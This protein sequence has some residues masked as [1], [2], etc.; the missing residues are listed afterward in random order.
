MTCSHNVIRIAAWRLSLRICHTAESCQ[1]CWGLTYHG[2]QLRPGRQLG[3]PQC[4]SRITP[5]DT[6]RAS[7]DVLLC[8]S[9]QWLKMTLRAPLRCLSSLRSVQ[10]VMMT[11]SSKMFWR[12]FSSGGTES[13]VHSPQICTSAACCMIYFFFISTHQAERTVFIMLIRTVLTAD[14]LCKLNVV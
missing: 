12:L 11:S 5:A 6:C 8:G 7:R 14:V 13:Q 9:S 2:W 3:S 10:D 1:F 4:V